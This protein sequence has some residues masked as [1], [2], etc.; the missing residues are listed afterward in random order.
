MKKR[1]RLIIFI[2]LCLSSLCTY[3]QENVSRQIFNQAESEYNVGRIDQ[4]IELLQDNMADFEGNLKLSAYR[5]LALCY[6]SDDKNE[7]A[8]YYAGQLVKMNNYYNSTDDP[9]R[10]QELISQLKEGI[11]TTI[12]T[13]SSQS[14]S[15][16]EAPV[17]ITIITSEM[18]EELGYNKNL[19]QILAAYVPGMA[20]LTHIEGG[21]NMSMHGA[22]AQRQELILIMENGHRLNNRFDNS[23]PT[24]YSI[25]TEKIDHIEVLRGP[26]SSLYGNVA[27][28][29][30]VNIITK[31]GR[32]L[33]GVK[34][35]Y[36]NG[37]FG[38]HKAD[39][40]IGTQFMDA[41]IFAW[42]SIYK[43]DGQI[44]SLTDGEGYMDL[45]YTKIIDADDFIF[46]YIGPD[47]VY[48]GGYKDPPAYDVGVTF[49]LKGFDLMFS[50]KNVKKVQEITYSSGGYDY[51]RYYSFSDLKPG[52]GTE[53][54]HAEIGYSRQFKNINLSASIYSDWYQ[55]TRY[56]VT[57]DSIVRIMPVFD[58]EGERVI[59]DDG[60]YAS[61]TV[62]EVGVKEFRQFRE[63]TIG[64][65]IKASS[66]YQLGQMKGNALA[67]IQYER[68]LLQSDNY[69]W[70]D[71]FG[72]ID[73]GVISFEDI[74]RNGKERSLSFFLQ[75]K[76]YILPELIL[77]AGCRYDFKYRH[78]E[79][80]VR[81]LSPRLA[82]MYVP[83]ERFSLKLA[84]SEAFADLS[85]YYRF[86]SKN[87]TF[88]MKPQHLSA[89]Q[90]TAMGTILPL[91]LNY[92]VNLFYNKYSNL[93]CWQARDVSLLD[94]YASKNSGKLKNVGIEGTARYD[95]K[96]LSA[97]LSLYYCHDISSEHYFYNSVEKKTTAV[98]HF[99]L[100]LHGAWKVLQNKNN[101]L[102]VYGHMSYIGKRI[103]LRDIIDE[104]LDITVDGKTIFDLGAQYSYKKRL[105][106]S[107]DCENLF[108]TYHYIC[109]PNYQNLPHFQRGRN[110]MMAVSYRF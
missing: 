24:S 76:N 87:S 97:Y 104:S 103:N 96:R 3:A 56:E 77:N 67:G 19:G 17:P 39:I 78:E 15:I 8:R 52:Y 23:G 54:T 68:F 20:E 91:H 9:A 88:S 81:T 7:E 32:T 51:D 33:D 80:V 45:S 101:E 30:V 34:A 86:L 102:K 14:E 93:L 31:S 40:N 85:Y 106:L 94:E 73:G 50:R 11:A 62:I 13:A 63:H 6:L 109:G 48:V 36:G 84:Y 92:E 26:A 38:T 25:S 49:K 42:A 58:D 79:D 27:L 75:D 59:D 44:R 82:M 28:S 41:D 74:L 61:E 64:G 66:S 1:I 21:D 46:K 99:T 95:H 110:L 55:I 89:L 2:G 29:A 35:K 72:Y 37:S 69:F 4:A 70:G 98:P 108:D 83:N 71:N 105:Q 57:D 5:L 90:L 100:N 10:F 43:S 107:L 47:R 65:T 18:I 12:T 60:N 16:N 22:Y 53:E